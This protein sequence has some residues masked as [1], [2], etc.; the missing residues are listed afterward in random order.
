MGDQKDRDNPDVFEY[1][2]GLPI[3]KRLQKVERQ[4]AEAEAREQ[5]YRDQQLAINRSM[6]RFTLAL[7]FLSAITIIVNVIYIY[8]TNMN[9]QAA[10]SAAETARQT[11]REF[12]RGGGD[13][14]D[15]AVAAKDQVNT[16]KQSARAAEQTITNAQST[17]HLEQR[18]WIG[19]T[20]SM[21]GGDQ[22]KIFAAIT[23]TGRHR[24]L[25]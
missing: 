4:Q 22:P 23:N 3:F 17:F 5:T 6:M 13:T 9:A 14:H 7:V 18:A 21:Q 10:K 24:L 12:Q 16:A 11:L 8:I 25:M 19:V 2:N 20:E 1:E 15:L